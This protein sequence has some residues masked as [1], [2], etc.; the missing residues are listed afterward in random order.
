MCVFTLK[1]AD[2]YIYEGYKPAVMRRKKEEEEE[3]VFCGYGFQF[4]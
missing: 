4:Y 3:F 2:T 1:H